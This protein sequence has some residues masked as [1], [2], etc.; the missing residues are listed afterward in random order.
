LTA[1]DLRHAEDHM[2]LLGRKTAMERLASTARCAE[3]DVAP[4]RRRDRNEDADA[5][6]LRVP[7]AAQLSSNIVKNKQGSMR[8]IA[9]GI[10]IL[11]NSKRKSPGGVMIR[12]AIVGGGPGGLLTSYLLDEFH[13]DVATVTLFEACSRLGG[14]LVTGQFER[15][16]VRYEAG[17][18]ELY[19]YSR[20]GPDPIRGLVTEFGLETTPMFGKAVMLD[21][22]MPPRTSRSP[23]GRKSG[24]PVPAETTSRNRHRYPARCRAET[25]NRLRQACLCKASHRLQWD[26]P[27]GRGAR[28]GSAA[29]LNFTFAIP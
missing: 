7:A 18:A 29:S 1:G 12:I 20:V 25:R 23:T 13:H 3:L 2:L 21:G 5:R 11:C 8:V 15:A 4:E 24:P 22:R 17:V 9:I 14:K 10:Q 16:P 26:A 6:E 27:R 28:I 19:D